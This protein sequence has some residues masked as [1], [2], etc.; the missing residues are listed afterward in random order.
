MLRALNLCQDVT[1]CVSTKLKSPLLPF[2]KLSIGNDH[3]STDAGYDN[4]FCI[5]FPFHSALNQVGSSTSLLDEVI[6]TEVVLQPTKKPRSVGPH[7][8]IPRKNNNKKKSRLENKKFR[9]VSRPL[10]GVSI[11]PS[12]DEDNVPQRRLLYTNK[13]KRNYPLM[14]T[15]ASVPTVIWKLTKNRSH[16]ISDISVP[17]RLPHSGFSQRFKLNADSPSISKKDI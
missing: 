4:C 15:G 16:I 7:K 11:D 12:S 2:D 8:T 1:L 14:D 13:D 10:Y 6:L 9:S 5:N 17:A 3:L